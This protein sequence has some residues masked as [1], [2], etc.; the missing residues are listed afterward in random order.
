VALRGAGF[1]ADGD[2]VQL[3]PAA[4]Q[5]QAAKAQP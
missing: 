3:A 2:A 4:V 5:N 1:L